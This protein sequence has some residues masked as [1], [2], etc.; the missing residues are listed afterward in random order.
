MPRKYELKAR[1]DRLA[2]TR[3]R[4]I[5][6][7]MQLHMDVGPARTTISAIAEV[8]GVQRLTVYR[9][10]PTELSMFQACGA[11]WRDLHPRPNI[12]A[13]AAIKDPVE[14]LSA[15]LH[16]IYRFYAD[17]EPMTRNILRDEQQLPDLAR[18]ANFQGWL[19]LATNQ[20]SDAWPEGRRDNVRPA[21]GLAVDF[22]TW[23]VMMKRLC[24][25]EDEAIDMM[26]SLV[27]WRV[28]SKHR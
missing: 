22:N 12:Q 27:R 13:L 11:H 26:V 25:S 24:L 10:F 14:R 5:D 19:K 16:A 15:A 20:L 7:I 1:A 3:Q 17:T 18:V 28:S 9:H 8:A 6:G 4:I 23:E 2:E 21:V